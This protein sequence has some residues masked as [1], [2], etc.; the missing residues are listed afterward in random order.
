[1]KRV[2]PQAMR[3]SFC[4]L[5]D[6][7]DGTGDADRADCTKVMMLAL[8]NKLQNSEDR[9]ETLNFLN[10]YGRKGLS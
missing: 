9:G 1:M 4:E 5:L 6:Q 2:V 3:R 10:E 7:L 8:L